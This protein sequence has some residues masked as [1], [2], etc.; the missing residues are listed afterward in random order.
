[1]CFK[2]DFSPYPK[3]KA[4]EHDNI[5]NVHQHQ[6]VSTKAVK[7]KIKGIIKRLALCQENPPHQNNAEHIPIIINLISIISYPV[8]PFLTPYIP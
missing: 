1:M 3:Q 5:N 2:G 7:V 4:P 6:C 8:L